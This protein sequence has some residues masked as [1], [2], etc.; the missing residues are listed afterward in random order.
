MR[1]LILGSSGLI[2][3]G[4]FTYLTAQGHTVTGIDIS[5]GPEHDLR[6]YNN[7]Y[8]LD[9]LGLADFVYFFAFDVG[10]SKYLSQYEK[11]FDF[12]SN[13]TKIMNT[14]FD[15]LKTT[16]MP[17]IFASSQ[18]SQMNHSAYGSLKLLGEHYTSILDGLTVRFWNVYGYEPISDR[19]HVVADFIHN[20]KYNQQIAMLT[21]GSE[22][23]Q[24][25]HVDDCS[26]ALYNLS[27]NYAQVN[28]TEQL[29]ITNFKW[30]KIAELAQEVAKHFPGCKVIA[31]NNKD[32]VQH[33]I[34]NEPSTDILKYWTPSIDLQTG[35][36]KTIQCY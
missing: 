17:F 28:R 20:A 9:C 18:M 24:L 33:S 12:V 23:R 26:A 27:L 3:Q 14:V 36:E 22:Q 29:H 7:Q 25:L 16:N 31:G 11:T 10:G 2:G 32:T 4:L 35:I 1:Y 30:T 13:N 34:L 8:F 6:Q 21:D 5:N 19:S 15:A